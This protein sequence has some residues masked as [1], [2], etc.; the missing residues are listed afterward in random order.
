MS[1]PLPFFGRLHSQKQRYCSEVLYARCLYVPPSHIFRFSAYVGNFRFY[2]YLFVKNCNFIF[3][4][5]KSKN[6]KNPTSPFCRTLNFTPLKGFR[7]RLSSKLSIIAAFKHLQFY[8]QKWR[9]LTPL[10]GNFLKKKLD[11]FFLKF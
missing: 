9:N 7:F 11:C 10:K 6:I 2:G 3:W 4:G 5:S 8:D 1:S